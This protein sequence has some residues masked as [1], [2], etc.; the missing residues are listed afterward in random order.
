MNTLKIKD[1]TFPIDPER[2]F[3]KEYNHED[4]GE[5]YTIWDIWVQ[6]AEA[7]FLDEGTHASNIRCEQ[8]LA[9]HGNIKSLIGKTIT[10]KDSYDYVTDEHLFTFYMLTHNGVIDN[11]IT[12]EKIEGDKLYIHWKGVIEELGFE[13]DYNTNVPFE[14][15][16]ALEIKAMVEADDYHTPSSV[17]QSHISNANDDAENNQFII[18]SI[19]DITDQYT[20]NNEAYEALIELVSSEDFLG[21]F[22]DDTDSLE[23]FITNFTYR[24]DDRSY[25]VPE[26]VSTDALR[27][28]K[29]IPI[30][31]DII[32][33]L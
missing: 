25:P 1:Y 17:V 30:L 19:V 2:S 24:S 8:L 26:S 15:S 29:E 11:E 31:A 28:W 7:P 14:L 20:L 9:V 4:F 3:I 12:F 5:T 33:D 22:E 27:R 18:D 23:H 32:E 13:G 16:C 21:T 6:S 10:I